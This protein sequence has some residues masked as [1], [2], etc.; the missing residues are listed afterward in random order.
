MDS[1]EGMLQISFAIYLRATQEK[2]GSRF[3]YM[4]SE[5]IMQIN[6]EAVLENTKKAT[7]FGLAAFKG[8]G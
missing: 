5:K 3:A 6:N 2:M 8:N 4:T 7:K 1:V